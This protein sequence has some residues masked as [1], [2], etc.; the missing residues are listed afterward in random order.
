MELHGTN[1][2]Q[3]ERVPVPDSKSPT[4]KVFIAWMGFGFWEWSSHDI[5]RWIVEFDHVCDI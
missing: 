5:H 3:V 4:V 2:V 1:N